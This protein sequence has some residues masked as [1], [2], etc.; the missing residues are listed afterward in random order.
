MASKHRAERDRGQTLV[1][2][3]LI[4][5]ILVLLMVGL[6]DLGRVVFVNNSLSDG[7]R[8]GARE[9]STDPRSA[10]Y[11]ANI[12]EAIRSAIRGQPLSAATVR[13]QVIGQSGV[14]LGAPHLL[15]QRNA[16]GNLVPGPGAATLP[17]ATT[18]RPGYDRVTVSLDA[19]LNLA[20][21]FVASATG[22][23]TFNLSAT[24]T[25]VVTFAP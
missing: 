10:T 14:E 17:P 11:C 2:F 18:T 16:A 23:E 19:A 1:E 22:Q 8:H 24:S 9:A 7:A 3:A 15:C 25:M 20:T 21:P 13:Y 12:E 6:F 5:P 4:L